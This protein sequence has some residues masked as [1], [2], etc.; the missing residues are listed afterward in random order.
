MQLPDP[1]PRAIDW[2]N[3][4]EAILERK[5]LTV[6]AM[7]ST[8]S[9][10]YRMFVLEDNSGSVSDIAAACD[11]PESSLRKWISEENW[12]ADKARFRQGL[13]N[14]RATLSPDEMAQ[15]SGSA[16]LAV[17]RIRDL[18]AVLDA[19]DVT[20]EGFARLFRLREEMFASWL[21]STGVAM[22]IEVS[23]VYQTTKAK[24]RAQ[25]D[26]TRE[27]SEAHEKPVRRAR[28]RPVIVPLD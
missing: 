15:L 4:E 17:A 10:A 20:D 3:P 25:A 5:R 2:I 26:F 9:Q 8:R 12:H 16:D 7:S 21:R 6:P 27:Q 13:T 19:L 28:G 22:Q 24:L 18:D 1:S 14:P 11:I 23:R